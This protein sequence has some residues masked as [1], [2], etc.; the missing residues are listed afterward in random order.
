MIILYFINKHSDK[1]K[2]TILGNM[3]LDSMNNSI[4][5]IEKCKYYFVHIIKRY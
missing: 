5:I 4:T 1:N 2:R 3:Y